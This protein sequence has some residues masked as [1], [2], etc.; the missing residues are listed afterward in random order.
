[1]KG[2]F[3]SV[4]MHGSNTQHTVAED[5]MDMILLAFRT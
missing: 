4:E 5:A 3:A 1:M 2:L